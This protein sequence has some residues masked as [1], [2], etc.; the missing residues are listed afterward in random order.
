M[1]ERSYGY[2]YEEGE[3]LS[4]TEIAKL[5]RADIK[6]A[7]RDG[8]LPAEWKY[9]VRTSYGANCSSI[10]VGVENCADAWVQCPG[11]K[12]GSRH[13]LEGGGWT[14]AGCG[15]VWCKAG[16][17]YKDDAGAE[18]HDVLTEEAAVAKMTLDRIH[19]AYNH[20][21]SDSMVDYFDVNY[22]GHVTFQ[23]ARSARWK[24]EERASKAARRA[25]LDAVTETRRLK[26]YGRETQTVHLAAEIGGGV[27]LLCGAQV[28]RSTVCDFTDEAVTCTRCAKRE[29]VSAG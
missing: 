5:I 21:G 23:D 10:D 19:G 9:T 7:V 17:Q 27:R 2:K 15:N 28:R 16:G 14:A 24:A 13:E 12:I 6:T 26:I 8:M 1:Y 4:T 3:R 25:E 22:Y 11:Y 18:Y 20:D 29:E